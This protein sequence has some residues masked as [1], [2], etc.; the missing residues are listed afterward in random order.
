SEDKKQLVLRET[1]KDYRAADEQ[2]QSW[3]IGGGKSRALNAVT[4]AVTGILGCQTNLQA[5]TNALAPYAAELIGKQFGHGDNQNQAAQLVAHALLGAISASINGGNAAA[6]AVGASAAELAAQYLI[7]QLPKDQYPEA[8]DPRTGEIDPN[9][10]PESVKASIRDLSSAVATVSGG[11]TGGSLVNAQ[12]AG[13]VGQNSVENNALINSKGE[14]KLNAQERKINEKLKKA[15]VQNADDYQRKYDAC[16]TEQC[17]KQ[18]LADYEQASKQASQIILELYRSGQLSTEESMILLTSYGSKMMQGA[19]ESQHGWDTPIFN[20]EVN[21]WTP[22]GKIK[23][24]EFE[25]IRLSNAIQ[26]MK[27]AGVPDEQIEAIASSYQ[28]AG[29]YFGSYAQIGEQVDAL[30]NSG[31]SLKSVI[32]VIALKRGKA[33]SINEIK[34]ITTRYNNKAGSLV[35][36]NGQVIKNAEANAI[37]SESRGVGKEVGKDAN[38]GKGISNISTLSPNEIRFSQNTVSYN[39][40]ERGTNMKYTYDDLVTNMKTNGWKGDPVDVIKMPDGKFTSMDN[41][42]IAAAREA[43]IDIKANV[44]NFDD[45]LLP[46]EVN[47]FSD[48]RKGFVPTTWGEAITGRINKQSGGFS[49]NNPYGSST[50]PRI[51]GK[52]KD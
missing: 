33:L 1:S 50:P 6:G 4:S 43:G 51:S 28:I 27:K 23:T 38:V 3:G 48:P 49:K 45:K 7:K 36:A 21:K 39:K 25:E 9:R 22:S 17:K 41:T 14:S 34:A 52:P 44:R 15:G 16:K 32:N 5:A 13:V 35:T 11:L 18:V 19:G 24:P 20:K 12:I 2:A 8:I 30:Y 26:K 37:K 40:V 29:Q 46:A 31:L 10:L 42:R 47:R